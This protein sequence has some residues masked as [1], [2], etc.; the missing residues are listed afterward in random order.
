MWHNGTLIMALI[1]HAFALIGLAQKARLILAQKASLSLGSI[2]CLPASFEIGSKGNIDPVTFFSF[3][4]SHLEIVEY[5][6]IILA[7]HPPILCSLC[8][9]GFTNYIK[10]LHEIQKKNV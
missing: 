9:Y 5:L 4:F 1:A 3:S 6:A 7:T 2:S 10:I 8:T